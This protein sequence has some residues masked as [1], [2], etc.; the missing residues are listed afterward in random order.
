MKI[1]HVITSLRTGGAE[2]LVTDLLPRF[3]DDG[4]EVSLLLFDGSGTPYLSELEKAG[5]KVYSLSKGS[6]AMRNPFLLFPLAAHLR[7][8]VYDIVHTHNTSCQML[9]A[10]ASPSGR[11]LLVTTEHNTL[12]RRRGWRWYAPVDRWMYGKYNR[13]ICVGD[14]TEKAL[15]TYLPSTVHKTTVIGNGIDLSRVRGAAP[16]DAMNGYEGYKILMVAAFR[17][18][19]DHATLIRAMKSLPENYSLF[20][21]GGAETREDTKTMHGCMDLSEQLGLQDRI[22]FLGVRSDVP[23]L[24]AA[25]DVLVL[26]SHYEGSP[27]SAIEAMASGK[28]VIASDVPGLSDIVNGAGLFFPCGDTERLASLIRLVCEDENEASVVAQACAHRSEGYDI[29]RTAR[30]YLDIY[31]GLINHR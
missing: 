30:S 9:T 5:I 28:P 15:N 10:L 20:L 29:D 7:R 11:G 4:H 16:S 17:A 23:A 1:L 27:L 8:H 2:R 22:H 18:Q 14:E 19:K 31:N 3:R 6:F 13:I 12:N 25:S 26:S 21:A 24:M